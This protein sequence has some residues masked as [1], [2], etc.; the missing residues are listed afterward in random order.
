MVIIKWVLKIKRLL[1]NVCDN[2]FKI[3]SPHEYFY[4]K[5]TDKIKNKEIKKNKLK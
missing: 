5:Q 4:G 2:M 1:F 3:Q